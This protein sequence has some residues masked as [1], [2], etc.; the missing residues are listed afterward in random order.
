MGIGRLNKKRKKIRELGLDLSESF[1]V[2]KARERERVRILSM[3]NLN[4][5][6]SVVGFVKTTLPFIFFCLLSLSPLF[7]AA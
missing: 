7:T 6:N 2:V 4:K 1:M 3:S 5:T